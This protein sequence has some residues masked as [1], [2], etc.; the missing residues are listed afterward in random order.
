MGV[1]PFLLVV[2]ICSNT[3]ETYKLDTFSVNLVSGS[4]VLKHW[5]GTHALDLCSA[6]LVSDS[7]L[8]QH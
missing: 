7:N 3:G 2:L 5:R 8:L 6:I 4:N 1:Q